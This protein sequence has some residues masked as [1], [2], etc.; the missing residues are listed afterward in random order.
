MAVKVHHRKNGKRATPPECS[1]ALIS[2]RGSMARLVPEDARFEP[3]FTRDGILFRIVEE[4]TDDGP[5]P[6]ML[7]QAPW[8]A[9][10]RR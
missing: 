10:G 5:S 6:A 7:A 8:L 3:E 4:K 2:L 1:Q 9:E